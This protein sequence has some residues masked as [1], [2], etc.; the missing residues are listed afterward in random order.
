MK[1]I[2]WVFEQK[3]HKAVMRDPFEAEFFTGEEDSEEVYGRTDAFVREAIQNSLDAAL[4]ESDS[5]VL[6]RFALNTSSQI[7]PSSDSEE[8]LNG[9]IPHLDVLG[10]ELVNQNMP[11]PPM[12]FLVVED[13]QTCGLS[14]DPEW[15]GIS[16]PDSN[17]AADFYWFWRNI[18]RSGKGGTDRGRWGLGKTVFPAT[19][20]INTLFALTVRHEDNRQMLMGQAITKLH[21]LNGNQYVP[22]GFYCDPDASDNLQ[23][24]FE[25]PVI[26]NKFC[27]TFNLKR[28]SDSGLSIVVPY[29]FE[30]IQTRELV[31][32]VIVHFFYPILRGDLEV[33]VCGPDVGEVEISSQTIKEVARDIQWDGSPRDKKHAP[34]PFELASWAIKNQQEGT[35]EKLKTPSDTNI[36]QWSEHLFESEQLDK[37]REDFA[38]GKRVAVRIP[39]NILKKDGSVEVSYFDIFI[40]RDSDLTRSDDHFVREGMTISKIS[41]LSGQKGVRGLLIVEDQSLSSLLGDAEGPAHTG[42]GTGE[43]RPDRNYVKWKKR[44]GFVKNGIVRLLSILSPPPEGLDEDW[45]QDIFAIS[46]PLEPGAKKKKK[47]K[48]PPGP[49]P[50]PPPIPTGEVSKFDLA[51]CQGGFCI[52]GKADSDSYP[53]RISINVAYDIPD[54]NPFRNYSPIDFVF[55]KKRKNPLIMTHEKL[56]IIERCNNQLTI[57]PKSKDFI[58]KVVG[59][60][61]N[62]DIIIRATEQKVSDD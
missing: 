19:S 20:R 16:A 57:V 4:P 28:N 51:Y 36:P 26:I 10:N 38:D 50:D 54:G 24:P 58:L 59:F 13:F 49:Q 23:M 48:K 15:N 2:P 41:T 17:S 37:L 3:S 60:D 31:R 27:K 30:R 39:M 46:N 62:R 61:T 44:V 14:G 6:V 8:L 45:L 33:L 42:W 29:P 18:G 22:E 1:N 21:S 55:D 25:D 32:T 53:K 11:I 35:L 9:L 43:S 40:E 52:T 5:P 12:S 47:R 56:K 7:V 34:P